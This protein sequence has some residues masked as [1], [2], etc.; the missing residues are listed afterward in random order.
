MQSKL[1]VTFDFTFWTSA[2]WLVKVRIDGLHILRHHFA[3]NGEA[4][5]AVVI[6]SP[7]YVW[8]FSRVSSS[9]SKRFF[10]V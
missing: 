6:L 3:V 4:A 8:E 10:S 7:N 2:L 1:N 5:T 9:I